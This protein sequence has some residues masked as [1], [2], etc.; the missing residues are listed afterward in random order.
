MNPSDEWELSKENVQPLKHGRKVTSLTTALQPHNVDQHQQLIL[1]RQAKEAALRSYT[2]EDP[3]EPWDDYIKWTE[4]AYP[5]GGKDSNFQVLLEKCLSKFKDEAR[6]KN[7][8]RYVSCWIKL[9]NHFFNNP[10]EIFQF[11]RDQSIG[12]ELSIF[13]EAWSSELE[14]HGNTKKA[15]AV[16][17]EGL[18][19]HAQPRDRLE[20]AH[21]EFQS[22]VARATMSKIQEGVEAAGI[23]DEQREQLG[24]LKAKG[25]HQKVSSQR[26]GS[27]K[28][29]NKGGLGIAPA[30]QQIGRSFA[31]F[32]DDE[33]SQ[34][35]AGIGQPSLPAPTGEWEHIPVHR[36]TQKENVR[37]AGP[38]AG[39]KVRQQRSGGIGVSQLATFAQPSFKVHVDETAPEITTPRR[40]PETGSQILSARKP[41]KPSNLLQNIAQQPVG[42]DK[43]KAMYCKHLIYNGATEMSFEEL[44]AIKYNAR[45]EARKLEEERAA[46]ER[47]R[48]EYQAMVRQQQEA[49]EQQIQ[50][51]R[52]MHQQQ[53]EEQRRVQQQMQQQMQQQLQQQMEQQLQQQMEQQLQQQMEQQLQQQMEQQLQQQMQQMQLQQKQQQLHQQAAIQPQ[54]IPSRQQQTRPL[55]QAVP[56]SH[57]T[58]P[59]VPHTKKPDGELRD[60]TVTRQL[61]YEETGNQAHWMN[62]SNSSAPRQPTPSSNHSN[63]SNLSTSQITPGSTTTAAATSFSAPN[64]SQSRTPVELHGAPTP[65]SSH[66]RNASG[67]NLSRLMTPS[68]TPGCLTRPS[69][70]VHTK[71]AISVVMD[72]LNKPL[73]DDDDFMWGARHQLASAPSDND[74]E[75]NFANTDSHKSQPQ[76]FPDFSSTSNSGVF[77]AA[78]KATPSGPAFTIFNE[79]EPPSAVGRQASQDDYDH[80]DNQENM[81][82]KDFVKPRPDDRQKLGILQPAQGIPFMSLEDQERAARG[83]DEQGLPEEMDVMDGV[84]PLPIDGSNHPNPSDLTAQ[85]AINETI[86]NHQN[87]HSA[88]KAASRMASTP[89]TS[90]GVLS[91]PPL[92]S[93][94]PSLL[95]APDIEDATLLQDSSAKVDVGRPAPL[96]SRIIMANTMESFD[97]TECTMNADSQQK[98]SPIMERSNE[99]ARSSASSSTNSTGSSH[100]CS[101]THASASSVHHTAL[102]TVQAGLSAS[103]DPP[104]TTSEAR[105]TSQ[106]GFPSTSRGILT[107]ASGYS[108]TH[109]GA[110]SVHPSALS[111]TQ[112]G[113]SAGFDP[114]STTCEARSTSQFG[115]PST[116]RGILTD[117]SGC[118]AT[119]AGTS[120]VHRTTHSTINGGL[121][122]SFDPPSATCEAHSTSQF[123]FPSTSRGILT[124]ASGCSTTHAGASSVHPSALSTIQAG[125]FASF[126]PPSTT[127]EARS[128]SQFGF[129]STS[130]SATHAGTSSVHHTTH[131]TIQAGL[132]TSFGLPS[133]TYKAHSTSQFGFP[134]TSMVIIPDANGS[135]STKHQATPNDGLDTSSTS[136]HISGAALQK[137]NS[138]SLSTVGPTSFN[139]SNI[140]LST[141]QSGLPATTTSF[142]SAPPMTPSLSSPP[143]TSL[144]NLDMSHVSVRRGNGN[145][146]TR[147]DC[148]EVPSEQSPDTGALSVAGDFIDPFADEVKAEMLDSLPRHLSEYDGY[149]ECDYPMPELVLSEA[150]GL[151]D[152]WY[153]ID[154]VTG[155]GAFAKIYQ[156]SVL[157]L[158]TADFSNPLSGEND[159]LVLKVQK[160]ACP[161][162]FYISRTLHERLDSI[163][164]PVDVRASVM[165]ANNMH[166]FPD[167]SCLVTKHHRNLTLLHA[168]NEYNK[169]KMVMPEELVL[170][171]TI[172]ILHVVEQVHACG[173][174]HA[175]IKPDNFLLILD[176]DGDDDDTDDN[177]SGPVMTNTK[178]V[179]LVD[180]GRSID[181]RLF[182]QG[183]TFMA[184]CDTDGFMCPEMQTGKPWTY[185]TDLFGVAATVHCLMFGSYMNIYEEKGR[186]KHTSNVK[187][188]YKAKWKQFFDTLL[189]IPSC[190]T[191]PSLVELRRDLEESLAQTSANL[192]A[193]INKLASMLFTK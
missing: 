23:Q 128:T 118:S 27:A 161:W 85:H 174:I 158:H 10:L 115:C 43:T 133:T 183:T 105:S 148:T 112:A 55:Q 147:M 139:T 190:D 86:L 49:M 4:Q 70:T 132:S 116:S 42:D 178:H 73:G 185:Q 84:Q 76:S 107:D 130:R 62:A 60:P 90:S 64:V 65:G 169:S 153:T 71:E 136:K 101:T 47:Q 52:L 26:V 33:S 19:C 173:I 94:K 110:S 150:V 108:T 186:W 166:V 40:M 114:P 167:G 44:R 99:D 75:A 69:P 176:D 191:L 145:H 8:I 92:S 87:A 88:F 17:R 121:F 142:R 171:L 168:V 162:E 124:D 54:Q 131:S 120:S 66:S 68:H 13:Y 81:P 152:E 18:A 20:A 189:N 141:S 15:D 56:L 184:T 3:L 51:Q 25:R 146:H 109:A 5:N 179:K 1:Q 144:N 140:L 151:G 12:T 177:P 138:T 72:M 34:S 192:D 21:R 77:T 22:R 182:P 36:E 111:T 24:E 154:K 2:G 35:G 41:E 143:S 180:F 126:D 16:Y 188:C 170:L 45:R 79:S 32:C 50:Q 156:A 57:E 163:R 83:E 63:V 9:A 135:L 125:L 106:F 193:K 38:W 48:A 187:R 127:Y 46:L 164:N 96:A 122:G 6:Y 11:M 119:H 172:E 123:D 155:E 134:S 102:S 113:L 53:L 59:T 159:K 100:H 93:I 175:D 103:F 91:F 165:Y 28:Q 129:P 104:S 181:M 82:P 7:D 149:A 117:E 61:M 78:S 37:E 14:Q 160:P 29:V 98:L 137:D 95:G 30:T 39:Q 89:F 157:T 31:V 67:L 97:A 58:G 74:F 80:L